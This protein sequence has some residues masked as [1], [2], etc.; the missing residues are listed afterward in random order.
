MVAHKPKMEETRYPASRHWEHRL[1]IRSESWHLPLYHNP[2]SAWT[3]SSVSVTCSTDW[4]FCW[5]DEGHCILYREAPSSL[6]HP[7]LSITSVSTASSS[8]TLF[9]FL[10]L[11][12]IADERRIFVACS[13]VG[14]FE[15]KHLHLRQTADLMIP[16]RVKAS[17]N[18]PAASAGSAKTSSSG[19]VTEPYGRPEFNKR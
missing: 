15:R 8:V 12:S 5:A 7:K 16:V 13:P 2:Q 17:C 4:A 18:N 6:N 11:R 9:A 1:G 3:S 14:D 19:T 10:F